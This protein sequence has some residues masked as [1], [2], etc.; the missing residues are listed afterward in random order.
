M[1][2]IINSPLHLD[3]AGS[4]YPD[5]DVK[6]EYSEKYFLRVLSEF[7]PD[8][9]HIQEL[10]SLPSSLLE[11]MNEKAVPVLMTLQDY[12]PLCPTVKLFDYNNA[13]CM[14]SNVGNDCVRCSA[15]IPRVSQHLT[16]LTLGFE[17][18]RL[19]KVLPVATHGAVR[20]VKDFFKPAVLRLYTKSS[21]QTSEGSE[22][23]VKAAE[24]LAR[25]FQTRRDV[26]VER[27]NLIDLLVA[28]SFRVAEI[29]RALGID[30][31]RITTLHLT[32]KHIDGIRPKQTQETPYPVNFAT[33]NGCATN[34]KGAQLILGA[35]RE[36]KAMGL[37][38]RFRLFVMGG[39][40]SSIKDE[41]L[42]YENVVYCGQYDVNDLDSV[43]SDMHVG[44]VPSIW[45]EAYGFTGIEF[46]AK[47]IPV[48]G[49][50]MGGIVDYT[51][52][53]VTGWV[54]YL[55][56]AKGL[57]EIMAGIIQQPE[58]VVR[59]NQ[60]IRANYDNIVKTMD[61]HFGEMDALYRDLIRMKREQVPER[62]LC[63]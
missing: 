4:L 55:N 11:I 3:N 38:S 49:N 19:R 44:I 26:N 27:L 40:S 62:S 12:L 2:E 22:T 1:Y 51:I 50:R 24:K 60:S 14:R 30:D 9:I 10:A 5:L 28:Q 20:S 32:L 59:L 53:N 47:G 25:A 35:L 8:V 39:L 7:Q 34:Q 37:S 48:I 13:L 6:E 45:E 58:Q 56:T 63:V 23:D 52:D 21:D 42:Q 17:L 18:G 36:L 54:N 57:T 31:D 15:Q 33:L 29:Y 41:L 46:I 16:D 43:L 61:R